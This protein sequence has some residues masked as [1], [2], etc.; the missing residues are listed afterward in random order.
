MRKLNEKIEG[1]QASLPAVTH[2]ISQ[3][4]LKLYINSVLHLCLKRND[5]V[6]IQT[7][8]S[9]SDKPKFYIEYTMKTGSILTG[10]DTIE[11]WKQVLEI[12]D[13]IS[14]YDIFPSDW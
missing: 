11:K 9:G 4:S 10:Y 7:W 6:G 1:Q 2:S 3:S 13:K 5:L 14:T 12:L 8:I